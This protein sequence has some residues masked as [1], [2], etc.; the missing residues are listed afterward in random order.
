MKNI[1]ILFSGNGTNL[2]YI[3]ENLHNKDIRVVLTLTNN[4]NA[5][6]IKY[7]KEHNIPLIIENSKNYNNREDFDRKIVNYI[8]KNNVDLT[9]LAGFM[10]ILTPIFTKEIKAINLHPSLLPLHKGLNAIENSYFDNN[11][12]GGVSVHYVTN[13]LDSG[14]IIIQKK[15]SKD[16]L[17][18]E[19]YRI[20]IKKI[21]KLV[22]HEAILK[23]I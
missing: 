1:A 2:K 17:T 10:R 14:K 15:I 6:G 13:K 18:L 5:K 21:E 16:N 8:K 23:I 20:N 12:Y 9:I 7:A 22:L 4:P 3:L 11:K 19:E